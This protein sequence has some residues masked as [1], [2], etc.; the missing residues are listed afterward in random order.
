M[1]E[2]KDGKLS[3]E[4]VQNGYGK[5]FGQTV[6]EDE[7]AEIFRKADTDNSGFIDYDEFVTATMSK[8]RLFS[9]ENLRAAFK[10]FDKDNSGTITADE[11]KEVIGSQLAEEQVWA[12][13]LR[14]A[15]SD[16]NGEI[17]IEEFINLM[18]DV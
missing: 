7:V 4:E 5:V 1:D 12:D 17:D 11:I 8:N 16:G 13:L 9:V 2:N 15:D 6:T 3:I 10:L 14:Q 18:K